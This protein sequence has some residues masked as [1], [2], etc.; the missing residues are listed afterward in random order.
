MALSRVTSVGRDVAAAFSEENVTF[1]AGSIA[2]SAFV[3]LAPLL[4]VVLLG[5]RLL[6]SPGFKEQVVAFTD[7][8][9]PESAAA[10]VQGLATGEGGAG[11]SVIGIVVLVWGS[12]KVFRNLDTAFSEIY[13]TEEAGGFVDQ[14]RDGLVV[15]VAMVVAVAVVVGATSVFAYLRWLPFAGLIGPLIVVAGVAL[16]LFP[17]YYV[18]PDADLEPRDVLPGVA[19]AAVGWAVLQGL[20]QVY[21]AV[22]FEGGGDGEA[23]L[24]GAVV[25]ILTWLYFSAVVL[26]LGAVVNAVL[27]GD[28]GRTATEPEPTEGGAARE[29][30]LDRDELAAYLTRLRED[31]TRRYEGMTPTANGGAGDRPTPTGSVTVHEGP[32][33]TDDGERWRVRLL[34]PC[35]GG[36]AD[37]S[38]GGTDER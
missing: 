25:L 3:S 10:I 38:D 20:F 16:A 7:E 13:G 18:F 23:D 17:L 11:L 6:G 33:E 1:M 36:S 22:S 14:V 15:L 30:D 34:W 12:L 28:A 32:V 2:Y 29:A 35:D 24:F 4:L 26:L 31:A 21:V 37:E 27:T 9:F 19:L 5:V 8:F